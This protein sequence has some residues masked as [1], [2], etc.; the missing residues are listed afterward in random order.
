MRRSINNLNPKVESIIP[1][2]SM[3]A[4][5]SVNIIDVAVIT[6]QNTVQFDH[7]VMPICLYEP[8]PS[9][10]H[11]KRVNCLSLNDREVLF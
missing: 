6:F 3:V 2:A 7:Y 8:S 5:G 9:I 4:P 10:L 1:H 11:E